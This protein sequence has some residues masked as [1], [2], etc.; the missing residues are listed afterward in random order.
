MSVAEWAGS[1]DRRAPVR[2]KT[3]TTER[4]KVEIRS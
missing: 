4:E 2:R 3:M 1:D